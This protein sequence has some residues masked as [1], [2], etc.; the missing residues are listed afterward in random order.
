KADDGSYPPPGLP[1]SRRVAARIARVTYFMA[2]SLWLGTSH[3]RTPRIDRRARRQHYT[4]LRSCRCCRVCAGGGPD[5]QPEGRLR[6]PRFTERDRQA[7]LTALC[8]GLRRA[9]SEGGDQSIWD[10]FDAS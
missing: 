7:V 8:R 1:A 10:R 3:T 5:H 6:A 9:R 4:P 2:D